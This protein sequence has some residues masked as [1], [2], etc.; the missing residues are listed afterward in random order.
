MKKQPEYTYEKDST[1]WAVI[2]WTKT[3]LG[4]GYTGEKVAT[5]ILKEDARRE[6]F[7]LNGWQDNRLEFSHNWNNKLLGKAFTTIRLWNEKKY[8]EG[9]EFPVYLNGFSRGFAV[10]LSVKRLKLEQ[11]NEHIARLDTGYS[12]AECR[13]LLRTMYKNKQIDWDRQDLAYCLFA[14][15][16]KK[17]DLF[18]N[19]NNASGA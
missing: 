2:R 10:L 14:F 9:R 19:I 13:E 12:A 3:A 16:E 6:V 17:R 11:I 7:R 4:N 5:Y 15:V 8:I 18:N 1:V